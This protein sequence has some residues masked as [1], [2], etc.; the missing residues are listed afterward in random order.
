MLLPTVPLTLPIVSL[1]LFL[2]VDKRKPH[3]FMR[4]Q[5]KLQMRGQAKREAKS[6]TL[7]FFKTITHDSA[8]ADSG[9]V[10]RMRDGYTDGE[11]GRSM[12][13]AA[14]VAGSIV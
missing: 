10:I 14:A 3:I 1:T 12:M 7:S 9:G 4:L 11:L 13:T 6:R 2:L 5:Q 8:I